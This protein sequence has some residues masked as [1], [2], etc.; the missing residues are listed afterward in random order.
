MEPEEEDKENP[1]S[2]ARDNNRLD[3]ARA[4]T[5]SIKGVI[6]VEDVTGLIITSQKPMCEG[7]EVPNKDY[8]IMLRNL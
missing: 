5:I 8:Q 1:K 6:T 4:S 3:G 2:R 7:I